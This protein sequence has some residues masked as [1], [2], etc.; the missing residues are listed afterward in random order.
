MDC[1]YSPFPK[2]QILQASK[3]KEFADNNFEFDENGVKFSKQVESIVEK[4]EIA[5]YE[6]LLLFPQSFQDLNCRHVTTR[7]C[8]GKG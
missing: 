4:G 3:L 5:R 6:Q 8:L 2:G 7:A 1:M